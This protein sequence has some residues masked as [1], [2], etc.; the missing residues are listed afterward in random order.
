MH[1]KFKFSQY[2]LFSIL[3]SIILWNLIFTP[4]WDHHDS[5]SYIY[6]QAACS[7][8]FILCL[9]YPFPSST[10]LFPSAKAN[11]PFSSPNHHIFF[12]G[13]WCLQVRVMHL[14]TKSCPLPR[15][16]SPSAYW[17]W[18]EMLDR[19]H[20]CFA[21]AAQQ[22]P[23][24][25]CVINIFP[26]ANAQHCESCYGGN[27]LCLW[28]TQNIHNYSGCLLTTL[29]G[30][31]KEECYWTKLLQLRKAE[32]KL[33]KYSQNVWQKN[34]GRFIP[35]YITVHITACSIHLRDYVLMT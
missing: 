24:T 7:S 12:R 9:F 19:Q 25:W 21:R 14:A 26:A 3:R 30:W 29:T 16:C 13:I 18:G 28:Q 1:A 10:P 15:S 5:H 20:W 2:Q 27:S 32:T 4:A 31:R 34:E 11:H 22:L 23:K 33:L 35:D 6:E 8:T 17:W